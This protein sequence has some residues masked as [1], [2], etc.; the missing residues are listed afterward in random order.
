MITII[1]IIIIIVIIII[2]CITVT[3]TFI[4]ISSISSI[5]MF[6]INSLST[7]DQAQEEEVEAHQARVD[8]HADGE[9]WVLLK[10]EVLLNFVV[11][12]LEG[13]PPEGFDSESSSGKTRRGL[14]GTTCLTLL[15]EYGLVCFFYSTACL[16]RLAE[17]AALL[18]AFE[19]NPR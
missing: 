14:G 17:F 3:S 7:G 11:L 1:I 9:P 5:T 19:E 10:S 4:I 6:N 16:V 18:A 12:N 2:V 13:V 15:V 8:V